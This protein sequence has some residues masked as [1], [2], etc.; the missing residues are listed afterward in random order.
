MD[1]KNKK[2]VHGRIVLG[3]RLPE[4]NRQRADR[5]QAELDALAARHAAALE[6]AR[7]QI[8]TLREQRRDLVATRKS[9]EQA[10]VRLTRQIEA[11]ERHLR[12]LRERREE[13]LAEK[14]EA[15]DLHRRRLQAQ[16]DV[17]EQRHARRTA[18]LRDKIARLQQMADAG[19]ANATLVAAIASGDEL[20]V[21]L[22]RACA[23]LQAPDRRR[24]RAMAQR[25]RRDPATRDAGLAASAAFY[26]R[27]GFP[28]TAAALFARLGEDAAVRLAPAALA[29]NRLTLDR[30]SGTALITR[31]L[32]AA[33]AGRDPVR[34]AALLEVAAR[35]RL[36][37]LVAAHAGRLLD[38]EA[39][40]AQL[41]EATRRQVAWFAALAAPARRAAPDAPPGAIRIGLLDGKSFDRARSARVGDDPFGS[42][43]VLAWIARAS[44]PGFA[45]SDGLDDLAARL[46]ARIAPDRRLP[47]PAGPLVLQSIDRAFPSGRELGGPVWVPV[48]GAL[49]QR[50]LGG[51]Y[52]FPFPP[53]ARLLFLSSHLRNPDWL[54]ERAE[55]CLKRCEPIGC[56]DWTTVLRLADRGIA[57]FY[58]GCLEATLDAIEPAAPAAPAPQPSAG[59]DGSAEEI[60]AGPAPEMGTAAGDGG[61]S[62]AATAGPENRVADAEPVADVEPSA[63]A[64]TPPV[65]DEDK[66]LA[67]LL[68]EA[69]ARLDAG[70]GERRT[71]VQT[72]GHMVAARAFGTEVGFE[73]PHPS[74]IALDGPG[75]VAAGAVAAQRALFETVLPGVLALILSGAGE[76]A[77]RTAWRD[78][79]AG[80]VEE[81]R[82]VLAEVPPLPA[83]SFD[84]GET[85]RAVR[86]GARSRGPASEAPGTVRIAFAIDQ[87]LAD[88][89]PVALRSVVRTTT[90]PLQVHVL[91]RGLG[92]DYLDRLARLFPHVAITLHDFTAV[93]YGED[94]RLLSHT[95]PSTLDRLLLP[96][97]LP[98]VDRI[99][100]LDVDL[101]VRSDIG[102]L[103][104][105]ALEGRRLAA[106]LSSFRAWNSG[107]RL[108]TRASVA[109]PPED[110]ALV[111]RRL[112]ADGSLRF[113]TFNAGVMVL[114]LARMRQD[115]FATQAIPLVERFGF[116]D[117]DALNVYAR[118]E[119]TRLAADWNLVPAQEVADDPRIVHW[120]GPVKPWGELYIDYR[121]EFEAL[122]AEVAELE[123]RPDWTGAGEPA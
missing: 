68:E 71:P 92:P 112:H 11:A 55:A 122:R 5:L 29:D 120:A 98:E 27:D 14:R 109:L 17:L 54:D 28:E 19:A 42:L 51:P 80:A 23:D 72:L 39:G 52:D 87:G 84:P 59:G 31:L 61:E 3:L 97:L 6:D 106:K 95:T 32:A 117:Q 15:A 69:L 105:I 10:Q 67:T 57:A 16:R 99:V 121:E 111:R 53:E 45:G 4:S 48:V 107:V 12:I 119:V 25:L 62:E 64:D 104:D 1:D 66:S 82:R 30:H 21:A 96:D 113:D 2:P 100:Y 110:G 108:V 22:V 43:A 65:G 90:R 116:N 73:P 38:A 41:P 123:R 36:T 94:L 58:A 83:P 93:S 79:T 34:T 101:I 70:R 103:H 75:T 37:D 76:D 50:P 9:A 46:A 102:A 49:D 118:T 88:V 8:R 44:E 60:A 77:V 91:G 86:S 56:R 63:E 18:I 24:A 20:D 115:S 47:S 33:D 13:L 114:N 89:L 78:A 7:R 26:Q 74:D 40:A 81:T 85:A 35:H